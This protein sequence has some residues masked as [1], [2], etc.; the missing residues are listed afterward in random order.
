MK[1][2]T[3]RNF[4]ILGVGGYVAPR[5]L[6]AIKDNGGRLLAACDKNDSVGVLDSY[7]DEARFFTEIERFD[8]FVDKLRRRGAEHERVHYMSICTPNYLHDAHVRFALR[9]EA[10]AICEK[11][12]V[13]MPRNLE[14]LHELELE[15]KCNVYTILQLRLLPAVVAL[16]KKL[17][18]EKKANRHCQLT[19]ITKRGPWYDISWKGNPEKSGGIILNIGVHFF[20]LLIYLFGDV[21]EHELHLHEN[22]RA[23]GYLQLKDASV[24]WFL[25]TDARDLPEDVVRNGKTSFRALMID[26]QEVEISDGF[27]NAHTDSYKRIL[28]GDGFTIQDAK[29]SIVATHQMR[30]T[31]PG[32][33]KERF[34]PNLR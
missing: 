3:L 9:S 22:H 12:L 20:D 29:P 16:K 10:H 26:G 4:A 15:S 24:S 1:T 6:R 33:S 25:S 19:Y 14:P 27:L 5:H 18:T 11:P 34:H 30:M 23:A 21:V 7:F 8:R 28:A 2:P 31:V 17:E 13:I 32:G